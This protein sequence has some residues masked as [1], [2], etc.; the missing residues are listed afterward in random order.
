M[1]T[2]FISHSSADNAAAKAVHDWVI[3]AG[4]LK[5]FVDLEGLL[6]GDKWEEELRRQINACRIVICLVTPSWLGSAECLGEFRAAS[7]QHGKK[8][9]PLLLGVSGELDDQ[10]AS[11]LRKVLRVDQALNLDPAVDPKGLLQIASHAETANAL[12]RALQASGAD[13]KAGLTPTAFQIDQDAVPEPFPGLFSFEDTEA[14]AAVFFGRSPETADCLEHLRAMRGSGK[15]KAF[16]IQGASGSGKSS[17]MKAGVLVRLRREPAFIGLRAFRPGSDPLG[18]FGQSLEETFA[19]HG[20]SMA[21]GDFID[22][23]QDA[24]NAASRDDKTKL[25]EG[26]LA[27]IRAVLDKIADDLR[28]LTARDDAT[29]LVPIDQGEDWRGG[30]V[31]QPTRSARLFRP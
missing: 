22:R 30:Q 20:A 28:R 15:R 10:R 17:L 29:I 8:I 12:Q 3:D 5:P 9:M 13:P 16:V 25:T 26:G 24:C 11:A 23:L 18:N 2:I 1:A 21:R 14:H 31:E 6:I 27:S 19:A 4:F 7:Y